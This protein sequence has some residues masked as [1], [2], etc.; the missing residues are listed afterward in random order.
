MRD[1]RLAPGLR[2]CVEDGA[3]VAGELLA[4]GG[5]GDQSVWSGGQERG[6]GDFFELADLAGQGG[7]HDAEF[8]GGVEEAGLPGEDEGNGERQ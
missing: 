3:G 8:A 7:V 5:Q 4:I 6:A 2:E 1:W